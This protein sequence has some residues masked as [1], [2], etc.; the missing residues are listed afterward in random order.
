M[1]VCYLNI[2]LRRK[3]IS[4]MNLFLV[5]IFCLMVLMTIIYLEQEN[6]WVRIG[7]HSGLFLGWCVCISQVKTYQNV[8][9]R[10]KN[11]VT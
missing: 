2:R 11:N 4:A 8:D 6:N 3:I 9:E 10:Y 1:I 7:W 5:G